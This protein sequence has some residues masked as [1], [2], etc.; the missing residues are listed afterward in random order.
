MTWYKNSVKYE[1]DLISRSEMK[2]FI[3]S[4]SDFGYPVASKHLKEYLFD[5]WKRMDKKNDKIAELNKV[6]AE[7]TSKNQNL[8]EELTLLKEREDE[9]SESSR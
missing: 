8:L 1:E 7:L 2:G 3:K 6:V 4:L 5:L 9:R